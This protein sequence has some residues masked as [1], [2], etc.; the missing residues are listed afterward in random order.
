MGGN[1]SYEGGGGVVDILFVGPLFNDPLFVPHYS[2]SN[3]VDSMLMA[4]VRY[5]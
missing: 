5:F 4:I 3:P 2:M 1:W